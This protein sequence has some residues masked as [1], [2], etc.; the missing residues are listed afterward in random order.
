VLDAAAGRDPAAAVAQVPYAEA[1]H[2]SAVELEAAVTRLEAW[3]LA[4][5]WSA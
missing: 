2:L 4:P 1:F 5:A 3:L